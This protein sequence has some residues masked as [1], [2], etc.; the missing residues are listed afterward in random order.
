MQRSA[1]KKMKRFNLICAMVCMAFVVSGAVSVS[2][3]RAAEMSEPEYIIG[4]GDVLDVSIWKDEALTRSLTVLPDGTISFPLIGQLQAGGRTVKQVRS[5]IEQKIKVYVPEPTLSVEVRQVNSMLIYVVG[6][7]N[8]PGRFVLN[9]NVNVLQALAMAGGLNPFAKRDKIRIM[10]NE[11]G[12]TKM[13]PFK[14]DD[15]VEG[16]HLEQNIM[17]KRG[18]LIVVP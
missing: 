8:A 6:R 5:E 11:D 15:A 1:K 16:A 3:V 9:T 7:V 10:R 2:P 17:L 13:L 4:P 12:K 18:D 14:Y